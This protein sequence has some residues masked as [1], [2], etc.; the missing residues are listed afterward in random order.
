ME[1]APHH[2]GKTQGATCDMVK[3]QIIHDIGGKCKFG[4]YLAESIENKNQHKTKEDSWQHLGL[5][6]VTFLDSVKPTQLESVDYMEFVKER[7]E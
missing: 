1:F 6:E 5:A 7:N 4:N 2:A 3:K